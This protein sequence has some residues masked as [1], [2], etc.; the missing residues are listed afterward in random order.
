MKDLFAVEQKILNEA[1]LYV[2][3]LKNGAVLAPD[4]YCELV[5]EYSSLLRQFRKL[6][7]ISDKAT[8]SLNISKHDLLDKVYLDALT[9]IYNRWF[10]DDNLQRVIKTMSRAGGFLSVLMIDI[11]FFKNY[12]DTYGHSMGD[13]CL[14]AVAETIA[15]CLLRGGDFAARFG[16]EE[17]VVLLP[18]TSANGAR[19]MADKMLE[20]V[21][22]LN[23]SHAKNEAADCVT[24]SIGITT[25][26]V[27]HEHKGE[28]YIK[29]ADEA[30]YQSKQN[31]RNQYTYMDFK[32]EEQ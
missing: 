8:V 5:E 15:K 27:K 16:G 29:C 25:G 19:I 28:D 20:N 12:N 31:G 10:L 24:V 21:R 17:F 13:S 3:K 30:L 1:T 11:D 2:T 22:A 7:L 18:N 14:K 4:K 9:G 32:E 6:I 26:N 23:V